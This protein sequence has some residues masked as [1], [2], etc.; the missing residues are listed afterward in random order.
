MQKRNLNKEKIIEVSFE[1]ADEISIEQ[2]TFQKIAQKLGIKYPS[3]YNH[4]ANMDTLRKEMTI[5]LTKKLNLKLME[6]LIGKSGED[7]IRSFAYTYKNFA[8]THKT[9]YRLFMNIASTED[10]ELLALVSETNAILTKTLLP[11]VVDETDC[12]H[13][14]RTLRSLLHGFI[15]M[16]FLGYFQCPVNLDDSFSYMIE[17][18]IK[19][20]KN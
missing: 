10:P 13:K 5:Y 17:N 11:Y 20:I 9:G 3:L 15:S 12:I 8:F 7:A 19:S 4:F 6:E 16:N 2:V 1:L 18:Y 14:K